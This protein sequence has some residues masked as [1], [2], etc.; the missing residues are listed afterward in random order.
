MSHPISIL[1]GLILGA[2]QGIAE[3]FPISSLGHGVIVPRVF[4]WDIHQN[5]DSFLTFLVATHFATAVVLFFYFLRDWERILRGIGRSLRDREIAPGDTD[6]RLGWLLI[7]G[8]IPA[9]ILGLALEHKL[10]DV[11]ASPASAAAFLI[12]NGLVLLAAE[13]LRRRAAVAAAGQAPGRLGAVG[14]GRER[15]GP[16]PAHGAPR[17]AQTDGALDDATIASA[18][19]WRRAVAIGVAQAAALIPGISRSGITMGGGL[20]AGL[21]NEQA[22]R[23]SFLLATPIIGLAAL[24]KLPDLFGSAGDGIRGAALVGALAAAATTAL[25]V[26]FLLRF[27]ET[28]NLTPFAVYC[29]VVG[30]ACTIAFAF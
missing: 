4:G 15:G 6:A 7:A 20:L 1:Q 21:S 11:F 22:A 23:F 2:V 27:F 10:R 5:D 17:A 12:V 9:G 28:N 16:V 25:A 13:R 26:R 29:I 30:T 8:T 3:P 24:Y 14:A 19:T 18:L